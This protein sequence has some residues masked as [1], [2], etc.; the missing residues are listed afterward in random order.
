MNITIRKG[1]E[2]DFESVFSL[3]LE[4]AK[5]QGA[6][7]RVK[8]SVEQMKSEQD[9]FQCFVAETEN[10]EIVGMASYFFA[11]YT[12]VGKSL[13]L[14]DLYVKKSHRGGKIGSRLLQRI[15]E[16]AKSEQC[17][18]VR[19]L[20]SKWNQDAITFYRKIGAEIDED[21]FVCDVEGIH[22]N[23]FREELLNTR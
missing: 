23:H 18:R 22:I 14:D 12:W 13:F 3:V 5:F 9:F 15:F 4:L 7:E 6:P 21:V 1:T 19:W 20:V 17:K 8:N 16:V 2:A 11:Y 10:K